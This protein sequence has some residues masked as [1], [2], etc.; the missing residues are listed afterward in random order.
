[1]YLDALQGMTTLKVFDAQ[2]RWGDRLREK[3]EDV[4]QDAVALSGLSSMYIGFVSLGVAA[5]TT[6]SVAKGAFQF[7]G[8]GPSALALLMLLFLAREVFRPLI[9]FQAAVHPAALAVAAGAE[10]L[11]LLAVEPEISQLARAAPSPVSPS[12]T[13]AFAGVSFW[14]ADD[15]PPALDDLSFDVA[16]GE[17]IA[18]VGRSGAGKTT[19]VSLLL[20]F[21]DP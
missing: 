16:A 14:Y 13:V 6:V 21:F 9:E 4:S 18:I 11:E 20:R 17:T 3:S 19:I 12:P 1:E 8:G 2:A 15:A 7:A 10:I 5:G